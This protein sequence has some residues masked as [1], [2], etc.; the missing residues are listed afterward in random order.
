MLGILVVDK[1]CIRKLCKNNLDYL[2]EINVHVDLFSKMSI[3][4]F[5]RRL[6]FADE[7]NPK[8]SKE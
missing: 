5:L 4:N 3:L 1:L 8:T 7:R 2:N 6:I